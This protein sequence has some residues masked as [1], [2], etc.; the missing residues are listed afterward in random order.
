M[1]QAGK[2]REDLYC[3]FAVLTVE[4]YPLRER[5]EDIPVLVTRF[6]GDAGRRRSWILRS[7][8]CVPY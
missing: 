7:R 3:R 4:I 1:I 6:L 5:R 8:A 2:F